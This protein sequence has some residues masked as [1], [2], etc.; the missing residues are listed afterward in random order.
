MSGTRRASNAELDAQ[1]V[2]LDSA[3]E[4]DPRP[5]AFTDEALALRFAQ[6]H[7]NDLR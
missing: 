5:P 4:R 2:E 6:L 3:L 1:I 7:A